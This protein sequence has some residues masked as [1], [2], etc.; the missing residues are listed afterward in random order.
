[1]EFREYAGTRDETLDLLTGALLIARDA[2]PGLDLAEQTARLD[3]L[4]RPLE[5]RGL[6]GLPPS[7]QARLLS[8]YLYVVC[9]FHGAKSDYYDPRNSFLNEVLD[10]RSG[11]PITLAVV[12]IEVARRVGVR[13]EGVGFP[14]HFLVRLDT[15]PNDPAAARNEPVIVDPFHQGR[16]LDADALRGLLRRANVRAPLT[17][18]ML[19]PARPRHI[20]ARMLMNLRGI[21]ASRGDAPRLLVVL[22]RLIDLLP[23]LSSEYLERARLYE[24]LGA[25]GAA[26]ADYQRYLVVEPDGAEGAEARAASARLSRS[27][28]KLE[29]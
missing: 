7:V 4:A 26:L 20:V 29:N 14:G 8:D 13:A 27:L 19:E 24:K 28:R 15:L 3:A 12:Y 22:D 16:L 9:G 5:G 25:P 11:I 10:R 17:A 1:V 6:T 23:E 18:D 2:H 21:Y